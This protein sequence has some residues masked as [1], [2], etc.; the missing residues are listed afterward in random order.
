MSNK[1]KPRLSLKGDP[2]V[3]TTAAEE[4]PPA[5]TSAPIQEKTMEAATEKTP[6]EAAEKLGPTAKQM[7]EAEEANA[8]RIVAQKRAEEARAA[9]AN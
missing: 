5:A 4:Q 9:K 6:E 3:L 7:A 1:N 8:A 2:S